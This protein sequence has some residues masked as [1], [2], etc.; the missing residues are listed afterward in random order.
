MWY[1]LSMKNTVKHKKLDV[2]GIGFAGWLAFLLFGIFIIAFLWLTQ[3]VFLQVYVN[4]TKQQDFSTTADGL[5]SE[6][7][8]NPTGYAKAFSRVANQTGYTIDVLQVDEDKAVVLYS[9]SGYRFGEDAHAFAMDESTAHVANEAHEGGYYVKDDTAM[10]LMYGVYMDADE[11]QLLLI[12]QSTQLLEST[13]RILRV[14]M[15]IATVVI[16][17]LSFLVSFV[18]STAF[19]QD[20]RRL[21]DAA[22]RLSADD[23]TVHFDEKGFSEAIELA[24]TLNYA[25]AEIRKTEELRRE[26]ISNVSH[27]LRTPL[28]IIKGYAEMIR[29][30]SGDDKEKREEQLDIIIKEADRLT[31][32]VN[33]ILQLSKAQNQNTPLVTATFDL[34]ETVRRVCKSFDLLCLRDGYTIDVNVA[35]LSLVV[36]NEQQLELVV[37]N[38]IGNA[39]NY[40]GAD[41]KVYVTLEQRADD[42]RFEVRDTGEGMDEEQLRH[43]WQRYYRASEH[44]RSVVGTGLGL[45]IVQTILG[46][47]QAE[48][49]VSSMVG[50]GS[51][52]WFELPF[53]K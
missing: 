5:L 37:Y 9:S 48:F 8:Y 3:V 40:T 6:Y 45:S 25:T 21:S 33:D 38:L 29:D 10:Q 47:H 50:E 1:T 36:G 2:H 15:I 14:Q 34:A 52:F 30:L 46:R 26:L 43:I 49:G 7:R 27:D 35:P 20:L 19:S 24:R 4:R 12:S 16:I 32:L 11:T 44:K 42:V 23:Y 13:S 17:I 53:A 31:A 22:K 28:T 41:K 39:V 51:T 18:L